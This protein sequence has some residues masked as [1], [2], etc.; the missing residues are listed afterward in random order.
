MKKVL[1]KKPYTLKTLSSGLRI[2]TIPMKNPTAT[3]LVLVEAGSKYETLSQSGLSH[4]LEHMCFK[5]TSK[6]PNATDISRELDML[7]AQYNAFTGTEYTGYYAKGRATQIEK[8]ID[9]VSDLYLNPTLPVAE[10][11]KEKGVI[12]DEINM[13]EDMPARKIYDLFQE[14]LYGNQPAGRSIAGTKER[15]SS[16]S[17][18]DF[19][20]YHNN[21][22]FL[23]RCRHR[24]I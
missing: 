16:F 21:V 12:R 19:V 4:F 10:I 18:K 2:L 15:V 9:I 23:F 5:G 7:G 20:A 22:F 24:Q 13:Y 14:L 1:R 3:V 11:E 8:L 6:R 17:R